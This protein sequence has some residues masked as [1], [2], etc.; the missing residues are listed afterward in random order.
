MALEHWCVAR[1]CMTNVPPNRLMCTRHW[2]LVPYSIQKR[3]WN[4]YRPDQNLMSASPEYLAAAQDAIE[5]VE[6]AEA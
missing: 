2:K 3:I 1:K 5:A 4:E 6:K